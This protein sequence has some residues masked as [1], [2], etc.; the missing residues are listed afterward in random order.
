MKRNCKRYALIVVAVLIALLTVSCERKSIKDVKLEPGRYAQQPVVVGGKVVRSFS[1]L[2]K[3]AYEIDD[4]TG[5]L[6]IV[7]EKSVPREGARVVARGTSRD[8][9]DLSA[10]V[11]LPE[12]NSVVVMIED[13]HQ[14]R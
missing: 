12:I 13:T 4:G 2:G 6:W 3:G 9:Y 5:R 11:K 8:A 7:A 14:T 10:F 1:V